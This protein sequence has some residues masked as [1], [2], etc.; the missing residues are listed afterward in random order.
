MLTTKPGHSR[1]L[2]C[3]GHFCPRLHATANFTMFRSF[4]TKNR[5]RNDFSLFKI[6]RYFFFLPNEALKFNKFCEDSN[7]LPHFTMLHYLMKLQI[8]AQLMATTCFCYCYLSCC[9]YNHIFPS[10]PRHKKRQTI[11]VYALTKG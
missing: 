3:M 7:D 1:S 2:K 11:S 9:H 4:T 5:G 10:S 6:F 8:C